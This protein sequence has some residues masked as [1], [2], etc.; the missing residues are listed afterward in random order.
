MYY[1]F[2]VRNTPGCSTFPANVQ[3]SARQMTGLFLRHACCNS[4]LCIGELCCEERCCWKPM[5]VNTSQDLCGRN[6]SVM[7]SS[8]CKDRPYSL[9]QVKGPSLTPGFTLCIMHTQ[10]FNT[11]YLTVHQAPG[12]V[13]AG[14]WWEPRRCISLKTGPWQGWYQTEPTPKSRIATLSL[15]SLVLLTLDLIDLQCGRGAMELLLIPT[16]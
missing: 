16:A 6:N 4:L 2:R 3:M 1:H 7:A 11:Y 9:G 15:S 12:T 10:I 14:M 8:S 13:H 5:L